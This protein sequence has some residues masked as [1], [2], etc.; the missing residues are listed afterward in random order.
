MEAADGVFRW[1]RE[2]NSDKVLLLVVLWRRVG[3]VYGI[4]G[5]DAAGV[6]EDHV[7]CWSTGGIGIT[8][9]AWV[10]QV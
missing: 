6:E 10:H 1:R 9:I 7:G 5:G 8:D 2:W 3:E 4:E